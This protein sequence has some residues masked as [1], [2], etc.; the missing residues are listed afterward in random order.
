MISYEKTDQS[1]V[2]KTHMSQTTSDY[3]WLRVTLK[4]TKSDYKWLKMTANDC[5][6][7]Y[8]S[9]QVTTSDYEWKGIRLQ[10]GYK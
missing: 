5:E 6:S 8:K 7:D 10:S 3:E 1:S 2:I 4:V 9:I